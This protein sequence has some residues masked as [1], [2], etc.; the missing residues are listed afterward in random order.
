MLNRNTLLLVFVYFLLILTSNTAM[1]KEK[2]SIFPDN[3]LWMQDCPECKSDTGISQKT[4]NE[5]IDAANDIYQPIAEA[6][7]ETLTINKNWSD[8]TVNANCYRGNGGVE[9][10]MYGGLARREE[11]VAEGF[12]LVLCHE[13]SHA[14]GGAPYIRPTTKM[15]AEGQADYMATKDCAKKVFKKLNPPGL[16][17]APTKYIGEA[18]KYNH[19]CVSS[20]VGGMSLGNLLSTL[21]Q[22]AAPDYET[23]DPTIVP[24]TLLS[25]PA[26]TQCRLDS[27][28][29]GALG[30]DRPLC[31]F[32]P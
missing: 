15:S 21:S 10:N 22:D 1:S 30:K 26:T 20:L 23:P 31:W 3:D 7:N 5:I 16:S 27:Y 24:K 25:Y 8:S 14:Y 19:V 11:I 18:C 9:I 4:F 13:L 32:K 2:V 28:H 29:N 6:N 12:V 17:L